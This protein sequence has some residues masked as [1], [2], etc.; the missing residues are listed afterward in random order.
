M[1]TDGGGYM[2]FGIMNN[3]VTWNVPSSNSTV[4]PFGIPQFSS[5]FGDV[6]ILDFRIQVSTDVQYKHIISH[7]SYRFKSKRP[8]G[9]LL[10]VNDI[11]CP[12]NLPGI[13]DISYVK[14][15]MTEEIV[16]KD[17][18]CSVFGSYSHPSAMIGWSMMNSCLKKPCSNG[19]AYHPLSVF[20]IQ[21]DFSGG[22]SF[23]AGNSSGTSDGS[24]AFFGCDKGKCCAC[25]GPA[26]G[27]G[28]YCG[29]ECTV[30]NGGTVTKNARAGFWVRLNPP[31]KVWEKCM[32]YK[33]E[34]ENGDAAWYKLVGD[35]NIPVKGRCGKSEPTLNDGIVVVPDDVTN[36]PKITGLLAYQKDIEKLHLRKN[37]T[38]K[39]VAEEEKV[40]MMNNE[41]LGKLEV[42]EQ[43]INKIHR[44]LDM[45]FPSKILFRT[46]S[47]ITQLQKWLKHH[48]GLIPCYRSS[49]DGWAS[50]S[51]HSACDYKGPTVTIIRVQSY[52]FGAYTDVSWGGSSGYR[53][54][55]KS[56][57]FSL[58]NR[59]NL[60]PFKA[61]VYRN[62]QN[63]IYTGPS[64]GLIFGGGHDIYIANNAGQSTSSHSNFGLTYRPPSGYN[65][66]ASNTQALLAGSYSFT[67]SEVEVFY[68]V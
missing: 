47:F 12:N 21:V 37:N 31:R 48:R 13:G 60:R 42:L 44:F 55:T 20:P 30:M 33:T 51:F 8:L 52:I 43:M 24:T 4:E 35:R 53:Q 5:A 36:V 16:S 40:F 22:L 49:E 57:I 64:L 7:W 25:Y 66:G 62:S 59:Y 50:S 45:E 10:M 29:K 38:W 23:L 14:N 61:D 17:F 34:E 58:R 54:S 26:G 63:A 6:S 19:F 41:T 67:P 3:T 56:F 46:Q 27:N 32:E 15:L 39:V 28:V 18:S 68:F 9:E 1:T 65:Y 11:G 2:L